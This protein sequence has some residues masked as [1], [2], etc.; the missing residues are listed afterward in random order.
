MKKKDFVTLIMSTVGG[1]LFALGM[2]M[3]LLPEW[4]AMM[5]GIVLGVMGAVI[6]LAMVL[7]FA[8]VD[9]QGNPQVRNISASTMSRTPFTFLPPGGKLSA[10]SFYR[11]AGC[12]FWATPGIRR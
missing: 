6:L 9:S 1:I 11:T 10:G 7:A 2:C 12:R 5:P 8:T 3:A 4:G